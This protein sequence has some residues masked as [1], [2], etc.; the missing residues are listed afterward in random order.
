MTLPMTEVTFLDTDDDEFPVALWVGCEGVPD[1]MVERAAR[2]KLNGFIEVGDY[3][4]R[5][6]C[7]VGS[8]VRPEDR[9]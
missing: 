2:E 5:G 6:K 3:K 8:I 1:S 9:A 4:P 7:R